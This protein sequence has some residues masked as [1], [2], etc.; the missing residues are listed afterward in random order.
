MRVFRIHLTIS[1]C[2][3]FPFGFE[4]WVRDSTVLVPGHCFF[5]VPNFGEVEGAYWFGPVRLSVCP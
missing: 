2:A 1:L 4:R 5:Y 3:S